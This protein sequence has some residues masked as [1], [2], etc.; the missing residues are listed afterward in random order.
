M[1][2][3]MELSSWEEFEKI[4]RK[5]LTHETE[6]MRTG[7]N[8]YRGHTDATWKLETTLERYF[9]TKVAVTT[10]LQQILDIK[11]QLETF[12]DQKWDMSDMIEN[13]KGLEKDNLENLETDNPK[14]H[15][16]VIRA[17]LPASIIIYM[18]YLRH[19]GYPS[20]LLDWTYSPYIAAYFAFRDVTSKASA[21]AIYE[22]LA[23]SEL[24]GPNYPIK[25]IATHSQ[26]NK[27]HYLQQSVYTVCFENAE[28]E[29]YF[30]S[31]ESPQVMGGAF[32]GHFGEVFTKYII[33]TSERAKALH[34]LEAYNINAYSLMGT[35]ES[36]LETMFLREFKKF[37]ISKVI[38]PGFDINW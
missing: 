3:I 5:Q 24:W 20:P 32:E 9:G 23:A 26:K 14:F 33:P 10:Y 31:H 27:R 30:G 36:L 17:M 37:E 13:L 12:T 22:F 15:N 16:S 2:K 7:P 6:E 1:L 34:S 29:I 18:Q 4:I 38:Y 21:V 11:S 25:L 35:E 28:N 19:F 8:F